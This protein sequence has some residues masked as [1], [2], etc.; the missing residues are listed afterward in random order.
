M[1]V[2]ET[3]VIEIQ[4]VMNM[5]QTNFKDCKTFVEIIICLKTCKK[6]HSAEHRTDW[7]PSKSDQSE[8]SIF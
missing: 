6:Y 4:A 2:I 5:L 7:L 8:M 3:F 1:S